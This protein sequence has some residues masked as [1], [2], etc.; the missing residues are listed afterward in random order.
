MKD[1]REHAR[2]DVN[3]QR[4]LCDYKVGDPLDIHYIG[5]GK[6]RKRSDDT[7]KHLQEAICFTYYEMKISGVSYYLN[8]KV[9]RRYGFN[10]IVYTI[11]PK[12]PEDI[13]E[14]TPII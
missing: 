7:F 4:W 13:I 10:E 12:T 1:I 6:L 11:E 5:W 8:C 14:G 2:E 9:H 3:V